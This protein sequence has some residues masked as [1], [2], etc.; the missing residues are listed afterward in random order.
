MRKIQLV[1]HNDAWSK[2]YH[3]EEKKLRIVLKKEIALIAH[4]GSTAIP[5]L[6][7]KPTID[8]LVGVN[9]IKRINKYN[10][11]LEEEGYT[12]KGAFGMKNRRFFIKG[13]D[14]KRL[15][16]LHIFEKTNPEITRH[17]TFKEFLLLHP[18]ERKKYEKLKIL[19]AKKY[20]FNPDAYSRG[21]EKLIK[22]IDKKAGIWACNMFLSKKYMGIARGYQH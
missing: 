19:L 9:D 1:C 21:K 17:L 20:P 5:K 18:E 16:H 7:A 10:K 4:I 13:N 2:I 15:V 3:E 14:L 22:I 12:P 6:K 8:I 11:L